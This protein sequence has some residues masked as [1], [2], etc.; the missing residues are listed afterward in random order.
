VAIGVFPMATS[1]PVIY[2]G[3]A[4]LTTLTT[5]R[6]DFTRETRAR[7]FGKTGR[8]IASFVIGFSKGLLF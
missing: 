3:F 2:M 8:R 4:I 7:T 6:R 5:F 1:K